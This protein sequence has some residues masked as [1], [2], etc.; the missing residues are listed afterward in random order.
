MIIATNMKGKPFH[1]RVRDNGLD[2]EVFLDGKQVGTG[3]YP[4]PAGK[5]G[6]RWGMYLGKGIVT[7]E[8]MIFVSGATVDGRGGH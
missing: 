5:T 7:H 6:F 1:I 8:A 2:Y 4:R 3:S